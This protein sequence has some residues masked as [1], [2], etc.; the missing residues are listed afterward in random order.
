MIV[1]NGMAKIQSGRTLV[2]EFSSCMVESRRFQFPQYVG[3]FVKVA[4]SLLVSD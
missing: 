1:E 3:T 2:D 4:K